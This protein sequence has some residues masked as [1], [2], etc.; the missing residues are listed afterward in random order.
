MAP[1]FVFRSHQTIGAFAAEQDELFLQECFVDTGLINIIRNCDDH[2]CFLVGRT[3]AG[4]S[5]L[6]SRLR[7]EEEHVIQVYPESLSLSYIS[8]SN[9]L[10]FVS[11][12][13]VNLNLFYK[14]LWRHV[15]VVEIL[16]ERFGITDEVKKKNFL[17]YIWNFIA[18]NKKHE[19]ALSYLREW[20]DSFWQ[21]TE[22]RVKEV[23]T[24][25][26]KDLQ[27]ALQ[28][29]MQNVGSLNFSAAKKLTEEQ[30]QEVIQRAQQVVNKVQIR[31]LSAIMDLL[32]DILLND[33]QKRYY[34]IVDKLDENWVEDELRLR[35]I[36]ALIET[37]LDFVNIRNAKIVIALRQDLL[38]RVYRFT[39][40]TGFQEEKFRS[41][42]LNISWNRQQ[43]TDLLD[44]RINMLIKEKYTN[45]IVTH[46]DILPRASK[47]HRMT[48][49]DYMLE[50]T[51]FR[52][53]DI[54]HFFNN[55][56]VSSDGKPNIT[57]NSLFEAEGTYSRERFRALGDEWHGI[58]PN[59]LH[60]AQVLNNKRQSFAVNDLSLDE[61]E[62][63]LLQLVVY[64]QGKDGDDL[65]YAQMVY[66]GA[67]SIVEYRNY[68]I[69]IFY[70]V[71]L[72]GLK[73]SKNSSVSWSYYGT[74][75]VSLAEIGPETKVFVHKTFWRHLGI[76]EVAAVEEQ[77]TE[78]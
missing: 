6:L 27:S 20:G 70:K 32:N 78:R 68:L 67:I 2:R 8:G 46:K 29:S 41:S 75:S 58:Y 24:K 59:L 77:M 55:C 3:G 33:R 43:L 9:I 56:I 62:E 49:I 18:P 38:D 11:E 15:F 5:A 16:K 36:R 39:R 25:L 42:S 48:A 52:P 50:R 19:L 30:R 7:D 74:T 66:N 28:Q 73:L 71:G 34:I 76:N 1:Q 23:T 45:L 65:N 31:E 61:L 10:K 53:R 69:S 22:Y 21:E 47:R 13:G 4:K 51:F 14:L 72:V 37:S 26:E 12:M 64:N 17:Q 63:N 60:L 35:L 54:I 44:A 40:D 57:W